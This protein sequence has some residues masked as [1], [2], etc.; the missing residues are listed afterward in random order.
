LNNRLI[1]HVDLLVKRVKIQSYYTA[2]LSKRI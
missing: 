1:F 2:I